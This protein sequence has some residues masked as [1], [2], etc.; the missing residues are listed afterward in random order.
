M[1]KQCVQYDKQHSKNGERFASLVDRTGAQ[2]FDQLLTECHGRE[3]S[4]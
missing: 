3:I 2:Y 1:I 4:L